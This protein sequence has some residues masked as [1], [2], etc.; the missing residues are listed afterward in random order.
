MAYSGRN[1]WAQ[2]GEATAFRPTFEHR[3]KCL[4][5]SVQRDWTSIFAA[6]SIVSRIAC[7]KVGLQMM[8][9]GAYMECTPVSVAVART[10]TL[11]IYVVESWTEI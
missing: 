7:S 2:E 5:G 6:I 9:D 1:F 4:D 11:D 8:P 3:V 10:T